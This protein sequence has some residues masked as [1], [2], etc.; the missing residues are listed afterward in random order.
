MSFSSLFNNHPCENLVVNIQPESVTIIGAGPAGL[1]A[2]DVLS[3]A[4][5][6]VAVY[7]AMPS[8]GRKFLMAGK[9]GMN[10]THAEA[11]PGFLSRY[12]EQQ[13]R[14][15]PILSAF[16]P[17]ALRDWVH[18]RGIDTFVGSSGRVFP[19]NM[20]A[21]PL[22]R[23]WLHR[24]RNAGVKLHM[25]HRWLGW[26]PDGSLSFA[27]NQQIHAVHS[28]A[29]ILALGGGS[30]PQLGSTGDWQTLLSERNIPLATLQAA[31]CGFETAWSE[32]FVSRYAGQPIKPVTI[33]YGEASQQGE[34]MVTEHGLEGGAIYALSGILLDEIN[35]QGFVRIN[36]DLAPDRDETALVNRLTAPRGKLSIS[37]YLR[38]RI[39]LDGVKAALLREVLNSD[40]LKKPESLA[41]TLKAMPITL[42]AT[43]PLAEAISSAGGVKFSAVNNQLML[44]DLP[45]VF[46]AG[47]MLDWEAPTGGYLLTA[48]FATGLCAGRGVLNWLNSPTETRST[49]CTK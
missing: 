16:P 38:K 29:L 2:A 49:P 46:C 27:A 11:F 23:A 41:A 26:N 1:M 42:T 36:L 3:Q 14:L 35:R 21:A 8:A 7:D 5:I 18:G 44:N 17:A 31:N 43:R 13:S 4:G 39:G 34:L 28:E 20:K 6:G 32:H 12:G 22:L 37:N 10:I 48:C 47:E 9:G 25:R 24:L 15:E 19:S 40:E 45:G 30:W 33:R